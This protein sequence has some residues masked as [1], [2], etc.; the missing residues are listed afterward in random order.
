MDAADFAAVGNTWL[1]IF[2]RDKYYGSKENYFNSKG[3]RKDSKG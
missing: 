2:R 3:G 1:V